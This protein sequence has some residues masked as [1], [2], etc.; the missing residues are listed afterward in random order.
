[1]RIDRM[2]KRTPRQAVDA[3]AAG[4]TVISGI[5]SVTADFVLRLGAE[6]GVVD[7]KLRVVEKVETFG[8]K[9]DIGTFKDGKILLQCQ[10]PVPPLGIVKRVPACSS[11]RESSR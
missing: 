1:M 10:V 5:A 2:Q 9:L 8:A 3:I 11:E 7:S 4:G 6:R